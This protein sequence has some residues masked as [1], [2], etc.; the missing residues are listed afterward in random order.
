MFNSESS[1]VVAEAFGGEEVVPAFGPTGSRGVDML[2]VLLEARKRIALATVVASL[3]GVGLSLLVQP[4]FSATALILPP[5]A[6]QSSAAALLGQLGSLSGLGGG[7]GGLLK[8]SADTYAGI[9]RSR[10]IAD[11]IIRKFGLQSVYHAGK[12]EDAR[13]ALKNHAE[14]EVAKDGLIEIRVED[15][16]PRRASDIANAFVDELY[17]TNAELAVS[18]A[19]QRRVFFDQQLA[20]EKSALTAAESDLKATQERTGLIQLGGQAELIIRSIADVEAQ[21]SS[22]QVQLQAMRTFATDQNPEMAV[23]EQEIAALRQQLAKLQDDQQR[24]APG[25]T[26]MPAGRVPAEGLEYARKLREVK[27]HET[28]VDLLARQ[29]EAARIDE[30]RS[31]PVIQVIDRAVPP[32]KKSGP[33]RFLI[34][35]SFGIIGF[36]LGCL[37]AF[38]RQSVVRM[39]QVPEAAEKL[40]RLLSMLRPRVPRS[41]V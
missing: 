25:E 40:D 23:V 5:Q 1:G 22:R 24:Q 6:P 41:N 4:T 17:A 16:D 8:T 34:T 7:A 30:A 15:R 39:R 32:D 35:L 13:R 26:Q 14:F 9:L 38:V 28:L 10:T 18:E 19:S 27:Y 2:L 21:I 31:A 12:M 20:D 33:H 29:Y 3:L 37:W 36:C 11:R